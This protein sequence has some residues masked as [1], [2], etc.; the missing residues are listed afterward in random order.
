MYSEEEGG[1][2]YFQLFGLHESYDINP[3]ELE[4]NF[5][6]LQK[7][8]HP[9]LFSNKSAEEQA[10]SAKVSTILNVAHNKLKNPIT[11]AA[12]LV[13]LRTGKDVLGED[14]NYKV[15]ME[16]LMEVM[17]LR[18]RLSDSK[19]KEEKEKIREEVMQSFKKHED[20]FRC[21]LCKKDNE[22]LCDEAVAM[23]YYDSIIK[24]FEYDYLLQK[25]E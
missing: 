9:D 13:K 6:N 1:C 2:N 14:N 10:V 24:E 11:R 18:E 22:K 15:P 25:N 3:T 17:E 12:Y 21:S 7:M 8:I 16:M 23:K 4:S 5:K 19:S 20:D